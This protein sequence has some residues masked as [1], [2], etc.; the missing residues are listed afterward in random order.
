MTVLNLFGRHAGRPVRWDRPQD[1]TR[2]VMW[3]Q[4]DMYGRKVTGS[5]RTI[6]HL[7]QTSARA[8]RRFGSPIVVIQPPYN[9]TVEASKGTHDFDNCL[10]FYIPGVPWWTQQRFW[11]ANG[12]WGWY[13]FPPKFGNH[14]HGGCVPVPEGRDPGDDF[15]TKVGIYVPDQL[16]DYYNHAFG[17]YQMHEPGSDKSWFPRDI[18]ARVFDLNLYIERQ[19]K[20]A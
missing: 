7:D 6:A 12:G 9:T 19:L 20:A 18:K 11:R 16:R 1:P 14:I 5:I 3:D 15:T 13:R 17:L 4:R 10:D 8:E 2:R